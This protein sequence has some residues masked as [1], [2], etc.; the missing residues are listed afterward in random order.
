MAVTTSILKEEQLL[1]LSGKSVSKAKSMQFPHEA[2]KG[3]NGSTPK[4]KG[5][6]LSTSASC[7]P[8]ML[9]K[10][11]RLVEKGHFSPY[12]GAFHKLVAGRERL[13]LV[14]A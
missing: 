8:G 3:N 13:F 5:P 4:G 2:L 9:N 14:C 10:C 1:A 11:E 7:I 6:L 12:M